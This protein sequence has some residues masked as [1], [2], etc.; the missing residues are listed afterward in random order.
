MKRNGSLGALI[1]ALCL[2]SSCR[3]EG[4]EGQ[5]RQVV[6]SFSVAYFNWRFQH[7]VPYCTKE[8]EVWL[9]YAASQVHQEDVDILRIQE[10]GASHA[11]KDIQYDGD[12]AHV[13]LEVRDYLC[14]DTIGREGRLVSEAE[15]RLSLLCR[16]EKWKV[17]LHGL[18]RPY[19]AK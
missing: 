10:Q 3:H 9:R 8:S 16:G 19:K 12:S 14:M 11:I 4:S 13:L 17:C 5:L 7:A 6:D 1:L 18:P 2:L 15:F